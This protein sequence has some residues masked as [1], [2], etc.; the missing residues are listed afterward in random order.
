MKKQMYLFRF[1]S[2]EMYLL[3]V[4]IHEKSKS[5]DLLFSTK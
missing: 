4:L 5:K 2:F 1:F 3:V